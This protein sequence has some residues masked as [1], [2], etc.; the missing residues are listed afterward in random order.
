MAITSITVNLTAAQITTLN[1]KPVQ[2]VPAP[3]A[4]FMLLPVAL[5]VEYKFGTLPFHTAG[6]GGLNVVWQ[7]STD[8]IVPC[9]DPF[10]NTASSQI[11]VGP[12][13][14]ALVD[15]PANFANKAL[16]LQSGSDYTNG[17]GTAKVTMFY[18]KV[19]L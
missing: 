1:S 4:S 13:R 3:S 19:P 18:L 11:S 8:T 9:N 7:G 5:V 12:A 15:V 6:G 2:L 10:F 17:D 16:Q 14:Q